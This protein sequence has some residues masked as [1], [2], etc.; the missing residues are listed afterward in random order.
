MKITIEKEDGNQVFDDVSDYYLAI[1]QTRPVMMND[2]NQ[3]ASLPETR[4]F[5]VGSSLREI[6]KELYQ[7]YIEIQNILKGVT[8]GVNK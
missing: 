3:M 4:S 7:S 2:T 1:R 8:D 5:S 6:A